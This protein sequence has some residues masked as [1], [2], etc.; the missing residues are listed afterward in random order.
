MSSFNPSLAGSAVH[1]P[2][3]TAKAN[4]KISYLSGFESKIKEVDQDAIIYSRDLPD[5][6]NSSIRVT[7]VPINS[8]KIDFGVKFPKPS[9]IKMMSQKLQPRMPEVVPN[10]RN[11]GNSAMAL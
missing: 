11:L 10:P 4:K 2:M 3:K 5:D 6:V 9:E 7:Q 1:S 8:S